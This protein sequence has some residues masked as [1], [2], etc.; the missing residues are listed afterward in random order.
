MTFYIFQ[1]RYVAVV[2]ELKD[3]PDPDYWTRERIGQFAG[4]M[5]RA[6]A[7]S[8]PEQPGTVAVDQDGWE[9]IVDLLHRSDTISPASILNRIEKVTGKE[10]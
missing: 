8:I 3:N 5:L 7:D 9:N 6:M 1:D 10:G 2:D 4:D